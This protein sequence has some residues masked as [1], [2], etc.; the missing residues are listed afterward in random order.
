M[1][2]HKSDIKKVTTHQLQAMKARGEKI[3]ML[4]AYVSTLGQQFVELFP[5]DRYIF[6]SFIHPYP[7]SADH[8]GGLGHW[9]YS[10]DGGKDFPN[11]QNLENLLS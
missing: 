1:S 6:P 2:V 11:L 4:T 8:P 7:R 5:Y 9:F 3:A 10:V